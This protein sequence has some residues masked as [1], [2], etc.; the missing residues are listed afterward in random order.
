[1]RLD[2]HQHFWK[3]SRGDYYWMSPQV[4]VLYRDCFPEDLKP[5]LIENHI[6]KTILVQ[7]APTVAE[8]DFLLELAERTILWQA[9]SPGWIWKRPTFL[10]NSRVSPD[11]KFVG[12]RLLL[13]DLP[14]DAY[15][16]KPP[17]LASLEAVANG[18]FL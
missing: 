9:S 3:V 12:I 6:D 4:P 2:S 17:V 1:M 5:S 16:L 18:L 15:I 7:A 13:E 8:T 11:P 10:I 14:D